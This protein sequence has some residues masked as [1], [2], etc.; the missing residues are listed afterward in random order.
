MYKCM[1]HLFVLLKHWPVWN[2]MRLT[3]PK[4]NHS[5]R[6]LSRPSRTVHTHKFC[7]ITRLTKTSEIL[8]NTED[9]VVVQLSP[10][11]FIQGHDPVSH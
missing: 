11:T 3:T 5:K 1:C 4:G 10:R 2:R 9:T 8:S 6:N 7:K